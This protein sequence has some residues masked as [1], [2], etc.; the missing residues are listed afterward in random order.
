MIQIW[1]VGKLRNA[2]LQELAE[3]YLRRSAKL[4]YPVRVEELAEGRGGVPRSPE[5]LAKRLA[6]SPCAIVLDEKG[7]QQPTEVWARQLQVDLGRHGDVVFVVGGAAGLPAAIRG[8]ARSRLSLSAMTLP[9]E[10]VRVLLLEQIYRAAT[11][12]RGTP[13]H[14][15]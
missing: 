8:A 5:A 2:P 9:H 14:R 11:I 3:D 4:G 15:G 10:L 13:Y 1:A 12:L 6:D 7:T